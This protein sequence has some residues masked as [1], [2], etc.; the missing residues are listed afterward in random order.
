VLVLTVATLG[1]LVGE[2]AAGLA[3]AGC[4]VVSLAFVLYVWRVLPVCSVYCN[5]IRFEYLSHELCDSHE[6]T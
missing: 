4:Y 1:E 6:H 5:V 3:V 2:Q